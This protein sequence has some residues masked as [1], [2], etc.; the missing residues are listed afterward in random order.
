MTRKKG[1]GFRNPLSGVIGGPLL[2]IFGIGIA[3]LGWSLRANT[4]EF[5]ENSSRASGIVVEVI[6]QTKTEN[7][8]QKTYFYP[9]IEFITVNGETFRFQ[10]PTGSNPPEQH[11]GD[12]V[13]AL[14]DP[15]TPQKARLES[16]TSLW[17]PSTILLAFGLVFILF[18]LLGFFNSLL[19]L[20]G[21]A[22]L[23]GIG[24][25]LITKMNQDETKKDL[26]NS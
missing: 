21:I 7:G 8:E 18:G 2:V 6:S 4:N 10:D 19:W 11:V 5:V 17:L 20:A 26:P 12:Q 16:F 25:W 9:V 15:L 3:W 24:A 1:F 22:G 23:L 14:Y 13:Q